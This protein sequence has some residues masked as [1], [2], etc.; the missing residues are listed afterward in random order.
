VTT[1]AVT[2]ASRVVS[3][4]TSVAWVFGLNGLAV[5]SWFA[6]VPAA[7]DALGLTAGQLGLL[8]LGLSAGSVL[9]M[10]MAGAIVRAAGAARTVT[11]STV[12][13]AAGLGFA[14]LAIGGRLGPVAVGAG[15]FAVGF[16]TGLCDVAMNVEAAR[17]ERRLGRTIMPRFHAAWSVGTVVGALLGAAAARTGVPVAVHLGLV[18]VAVGGATAAAART[19]L[20]PDGEQEGPAGPRVSVLRA[21]LEPR[22]LLIGLFVLIMAFTEGTANDWLAVATIDGYHVGPALGA[23]TFAVF[24]AAM[25]AGRTFGTTALDRWGR[26]PVLLVSALLAATGALIT[27]L[28]GRLSLAVLGVVLWGLGAALGFPMGMSAAADE[29]AL[30]P[31][32]VSV[33]AVIGY[34]AFL[35]GPPAVGLLGDHVGTLRALLAVPVML[36]AALALA[37][38]LARPKADSGRGDGT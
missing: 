15:L 5:A 23:V 29:E 13:L 25:T 10:P 24:V 36:L 22:T 38:K 30:A 33:V 35:A 21:W 18:A 19:F 20:T 2:D 7:R 31:A 14:G 6:R 8:L 26:V 3:A 32:R 9:A 1:T 12:V 28:A 17:V 37:P 34:T 27:V 16:G 4:R 11:G